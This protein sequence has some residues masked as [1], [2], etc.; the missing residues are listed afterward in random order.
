MAVLILL[1]MKLTMNNVD[2]KNGRAQESMSFDGKQGDFA[3]ITPADPGY[4]FVT[5]RRVR[6][7]A[8]PMWFEFANSFS[9]DAWIYPQ[10]L[11]PGTEIEGGII[12]C[13]VTDI[14]LSR[15]SGFGIVV[16]GSDSEGKIIF[17]AT[18]GTNQGSVRARLI[19][20]AWQH[21]AATYNAG[22][23]G[24][25][26]MTCKPAY[27]QLFLDGLL[28][29]SF[30]FTQFG[31]VTFWPANDLTMGMHMPIPEGTG[32]SY[33]F[34][35]LL[36]EMRMWRRDLSSTEIQ[37]YKHA[38]IAIRPLDGR[39][40]DLGLEAYW[41]M[42]S[43][44]CTAEVCRGSSQQWNQATSQDGIFL[45]DSSPLNSPKCLGVMF[46]NNQNTAAGTPLEVNACG[47]S[48]G[49]HMRWSRS[50][51]GLLQPAH[52]FFSC[53]A[54]RKE[55]PW[56]GQAVVIETCAFSMDASDS[57]HQQWDITP[58]GDS[59]TTTNV[60]TSPQPTNLS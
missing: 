30:T 52:S 8:E 60:T 51:L 24:C 57:L 47:N 7:N 20:G 16:S 28:V 40:A 43:G 12:T 36:D 11:F 29:D 41:P 54:I 5:P 39:A 21:F 27:M 33:Y 2:A 55:A 17:R 48:P 44:V 4:I 25:T 13:L 18:Q 45:L 32:T 31:A 9:I 38:T 49:G 22:E 35:G 42:N 58:E 10:R 14:P 6:E 46:L 19:E 34:A 59:V 3:D 15:Y 37:Y 53:M 1:T 26:R 50:S 23:L 56:Q